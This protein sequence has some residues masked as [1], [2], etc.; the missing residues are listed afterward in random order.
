MSSVRQSKKKK[1]P[2]NRDIS[3]RSR[4]HDVITEKEVDFEHRS[5]LYCYIVK[6]DWEAAIKRC[7]KAPE[8]A[9]IWIVTKGL[10]GNLRFLPLHKACVL[11]APLDL[12]ENLIQAYPEGVSCEDHDGWI[13]IHC[14]SYTGA[15]EIIEALLKVYSSGAQNKDDKGLLPLHYA[16]MKG[17]DPK[18]IELLILSYPA[19]VTIKDN[20]GRLPIYYTI[21]KGRSIIAFELLLN[22]NAN[23]LKITDAS[24]RTLLHQVCME[25]RLDGKIILKL[26]E[27]YPD[28]SQIQ[29][30]DGNLPIHILCQK[31]EENLEA[32]E[33][34]L[35]VFPEGSNVKN[36]VGNTPLILV[37]ND[38]TD[39][40]SS[41]ELLRKFEKKE[42]TNVKSASESSVQPV[43]E[44]PLKYIPFETNNDEIRSHVAGLN[45]NLM[46]L[47][48][49]F[50][51]L[52]YLRTDI[53]QTLNKAKDNRRI[54]NNLNDQLEEINCNSTNSSRLVISDIH[55]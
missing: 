42:S 4:S 1:K 52:S 17:V 40:K 6:R 24:N 53:Q 5:P 7:K 23:V 31:K 30:E 29:D 41:I 26:L 27:Y 25:K 10:K 16:C 51:E 54:F 43:V 46:E 22:T 44:N 45:R 13:P 21:T 8:E 19:A 35:N 11:R 14:A 50:Q 36:N 3:L 34:L 47:C 15:S 9:S 55:I 20:A 12:I 48:Q 33:G 49:V 39:K 37:M 28:S 18:I 32:L 38:S 2:K